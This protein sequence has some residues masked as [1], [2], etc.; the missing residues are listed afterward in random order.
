MKC[1]AML[2]M[3]LSIALCCAETPGVCCS[4]A[5]R[6]AGLLA[7]DHG[8]GALV[9]FV[10]RRWP[11]S[12]SDRLA[13]RVHGAAPELVPLGPDD[14]RRKLRSA[15]AL[16]CCDLHHVPFLFREFASILQT[17]VDSDTKV[18]VLLE[19]SRSFQ[20]SLDACCSA[21][22]DE[23]L[24]GTLVEKFGAGRFDGSALRS[25]VDLCRRH[26]RVHLIAVTP[27]SLSRA[28]LGLD[29][30][31]RG[32]DAALLGAVKRHRSLG[33]TVVVVAGMAHAVG[34]TRWTKGV[35]DEMRAHDASAL[36][37]GVGVPAWERALRR[38]R[39]PANSWFE[40][41]SWFV[42][43]SPA[44]SAWARCPIPDRGG[45]LPLDE[46]ATMF[47]DDLERHRDRIE[48]LA[49]EGTVGEQQALL[50]GLRG[51]SLWRAP[52]LTGPL[53]AMLETPILAS[54]CARL[55]RTCS[56]GDSADVERLSRRVGRLEL[57][58]QERFDLAMALASN[59]ILTVAVTQ[60]LLKF[61]IDRL[62]EPDLR[63]LLYLFGNV[64]PKSEVLDAWFGRVLHVYPQHRAIVKRAMRRI[65]ARGPGTGSK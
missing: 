23:E 35:F 59:Y 58:S 49:R 62:S 48:S 8:H 6:A 63:E 53:V 27:V 36:C 55:L 61:D 17:V 64:M 5:R 38:H 50:R 33:S 26:K 20:P 60:S 10:G 52:W 34:G 45:A 24:M 30:Y 39:R 42:Y 19:M 65:H 44:P 57:P 41:D 7:C 56:I 12:S 40:L 13:L 14:V 22:G 46:I 29:V 18:V 4:P 28:D 43:R 9:S 31:S 37:V 11:E 51:R 21:E 32:L 47:L 54:D 1:V 2:S 3:A 25:V 15:G 16:F